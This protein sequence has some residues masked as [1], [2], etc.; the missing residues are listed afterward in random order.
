M[1]NKAWV[2][3]LA[4]KAHY[5]SLSRNFSILGSMG[6]RP[7][8]AHLLGRER[9]KFENHSNKEC[10]KLSIKFVK[11]IYQIIKLLLFN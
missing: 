1:S 5:W 11:P 3:K 6:V 9:K 8:K 2:F 7:E 4:F 10:I